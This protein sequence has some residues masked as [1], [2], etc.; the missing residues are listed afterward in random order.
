[1]TWNNERDVE[2]F[3]S[4]DFA[5]AR[6][7]SL[8]SGSIAPGSLARLEKPSPNGR[9][10]AVPSSIS[11]LV[12]S[13]MIAHPPTSSSQGFHTSLV[14]PADGRH[15]EPPVASPPRP[16]RA[17]TLDLDL[18][19]ENLK[20]TFEVYADVKDAP[21]AA[22]L[23]NRSGKKVVLLK[24]YARAGK[25]LM[26]LTR[27]MHTL[28]VS[29]MITGAAVLYAL[30]NGFG[31]T[32]SLDQALDLPIWPYF[33]PFWKP[34]NKSFKAITFRNCLQYRVGL[35]MTG[36][37]ESLTTA[38]IRGFYEN[39]MYMGGV[40]D[41]KIEKGAVLY[42]YTNACFSWF[43]IALFYMTASSELRSAID[44][45][46]NSYPLTWEKIVSQYFVSYVRSAFFSSKDLWAYANP[47]SNGY[48]ASDETL[49]YSYPPLASDG[50]HAD[51][52]TFGVGA[53]GWFVSPNALHDF[54]RTIRWG[55]V[56]K[57]SAIS[58]IFNPSSPN[59]PEAFLFTQHRNF[60][61]EHGPVLVKVGSVNR[62]KAVVMSGPGD[63]MVSLQT[64][65]NAGSSAVLARIILAYGLSW[66]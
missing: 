32:T 64:N 14:H 45:L 39:G 66:V 60:S 5:I 34:V 6:N 52:H 61:D 20:T 25:E 55:T 35:S 36:G 24:G 18:F 65:C 51:D 59:S 48:T 50:K 58:K 56:L 19:G 42:Q 46:Y 23:S 41:P 21:Y 62:A 29:K 31:G 30:Q 12:S 9:Q 17:S 53:S 3:G 11:R 28:S 1:M 47:R 27:P 15:A 40:I 54:M 4:Q 7:Q 8:A 57:K 10:T 13:S 22:I 16:M 44:L 43:R 63:V 2:F 37:A 38:A 26:N 33:P 49:Y